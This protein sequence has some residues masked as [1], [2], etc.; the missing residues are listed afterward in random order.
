M[1]RPPTRMM[2][3][4]DL[5]C[6]VL[7]PDD[8]IFEPLVAL[9]DDVARGQPLGRLHNPRQPD[10]SPTVIEAPRPGTVICHRPLPMTRQGDCLYIIADDL[11]DGLPIARPWGL[12]FSY[13]VSD[14][15]EHLAHIK[16]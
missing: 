11:V 10:R 8:G 3:T 5:D 2:A 4:P 12:D 15:G 1:G 13:Q 9:E 6:L 16:R 14:N 7:S